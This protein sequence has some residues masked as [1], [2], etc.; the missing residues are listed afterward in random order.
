MK[1]DAVLPPMSLR[2]VP[3]LVESVDRIGFDSLW[4]TE[5]QHDPFLPLALIAEHSQQLHFGTAVAIGFARSPTTLAHTAWDLA[6]ASSGRFIL[7]LGTQVRA[8][9]ERRF[10]MPWPDSPVGKLREM[11][12]A[13]RSIWKAWQGRERLDVQGEYFNLSLMT[14]FFSPGVIDHP[15]IPIFLAG[16]NIGMA[17]LAGEVAQGFHV[18]PYHSPRYLQEVLLPALVEGAARAGRESRDT[19]LSITALVACDEQE[20]FFMRSQI[21]FYAS[22][23]SYRP[24]MDLHGW[25]EVADRLRTLSR[26]G[27]WTEMTALIGDDMLRTFAVVAPPEEIGQALKARYDGLADHL[28]LYTPFVPGQRDEFWRTIVK[29]LKED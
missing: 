20:Q 19:K 18:H 7:G 27:E 6:Q 2:E 21:A 26:E 24:V 25:G 8:H 15:H 16:V 14:P 11:V 13:M 9:V 28:A 22:T 3:A 17:R 29:Q 23:P 1:F 12:L 10:G 5:T 4:T